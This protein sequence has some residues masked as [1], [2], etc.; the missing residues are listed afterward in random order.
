MTLLLEHNSVVVHNDG[1][2]TINWML[3]GHPYV[4]A[5][6]TSATVPFPLVCKELGDPRSGGQEQVIRLEGGQLLRIPARD[7][8]RKRLDT[9]YGV[10]ARVVEAW[11]DRQERITL[12][13]PE[14]AP[15]VR[16]TT[17]DGE[18]IDCVVNDWEGTNQLLLPHDMDSPDALRA[19][20]AQVQ[21]EQDQLRRMLE[22][23]LNQP[24][25][26]PEVVPEDTPGASPLA[27]PVVVEP[28][29]DNPNLEI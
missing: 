13:V 18:P 6:G 25:L 15:R 19:Q 20:L 28:P 9:L 2:A 3:N 11:M 27:V 16:V 4:I 26:D 23:K 1:P 14:V 12:S 5:P 10:S 8:E 17:T 22:A 7:W 29:E 21:R 24:G